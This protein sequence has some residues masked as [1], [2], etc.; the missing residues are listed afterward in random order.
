MQSRQ[1]LLPNPKS[2]TLYTMIITYL[3][4]EFVKV[5]FGETVLA[6]N[7]PSKSSKLKTPRFGADIAL[8]TINHPDCNGFE[9]VT[10]GDRAPFIINGSGE[11]EIKGITVKGFAGESRY[12]GLPERISRN[13]NRAGEKKINTVYLVTLEGMH[14]CF[15]GAISARELPNSIRESIDEIDILFVPIGGD[16]VLSP[17]LAHALALSLEPRLIIPIHYGEIGEKN[18]LKTFLKEAGEEQIKPIEKLT[19]KKKDLDGKEEEIVVLQ[20]NT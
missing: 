12:G 8:S 19:I 4:G 6:F 20:T 5:Q 3:G 16:G 14:L 1:P 2:Y 17:T 7:P 11:Y 18:A 13:E 9:A 15:L 10:H